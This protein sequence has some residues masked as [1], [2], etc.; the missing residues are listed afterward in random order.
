[1]I[2]A[3][4]AHTPGEVRASYGSGAQ[5][6]RCAPGPSPLAEDRRCS[7]G[8]GRAE[9]TTELLAAA[10]AQIGEREVDG[11]A[12]LQDAQLADPVQV[13]L[14]AIPAGSGAVRVEQGVP[15]QA[16]QA[17]KVGQDHLALMVVG[18]ARVSQQ[19]PIDVT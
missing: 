18:M 1:M 9:A 4:L 12:G 11:R 7:P 13:L 2:A 5:T 8:R 16:E 3:N 15:G 19:A 17:V 10:A 14:P 6:G